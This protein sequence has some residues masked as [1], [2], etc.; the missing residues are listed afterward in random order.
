MEPVGWKGT[1]KHMY[2]CVKTYVWEQK[3]EFIG[4]L[5]C[6]SF[7]DVKSPFFYSL[8]FLLLVV[9]IEKGFQV[10]NLGAIH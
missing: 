2:L 7:C 4:F 8:I 10:F 3:S 9:C 1:G 5:L 6:Q